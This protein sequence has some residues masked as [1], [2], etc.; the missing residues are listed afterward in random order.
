MSQDTLTL[1]AARRVFW[2]VF[3]AT[4][5]LKLLLAGVFPFTGDEAFFYQWGVRPAWHYSDHPPL[6]GWLLALLHAVSDAPLVLRSVTLLVTSAIALLVVDLLRRLLPEDRE[7]QAWLAGAVYLAMPWSWM[8]VLVTTDTLLILF[9]ALSFWAYVRADGADTADAG[10]RATAWYLLCGALLGAAFFSKYF[11]ALLGFAYAAHAWGWRRERWWAPF[12]V[13]ATAL[14]AIAANLYLNATHGWSHVMFNVFNRNE[15]SAWSLTTWLTYVAMALYLVTPWWLWRAARSRAPEGVSRTARTTLAVLWL[16]PFAVFALL[17]MRRTIGLHWVLGFVPVFVV[18]AGLRT[19][20]RP[21]RRLLTYTTL[22]S[23][24]HLVAVLLIALAP[25]SWFAH[26]KWADRAVFLR[27]NA[28]VVAGL[29]QGLPAG[30]TLMAQAYNPAAMLAF[31]AGVYIPVFGPGRHHARQDDQIVDFRTYDGRPIRVFH[32]DEPD[33]ARY[34]PYFERVRKQSYEVDGVRFWYVDGEGF[35]Y[36]PYRDEVLAAVARDFH[37]I[38]RWLPV[39][40]N[41]FC[42]RYGFAACSPGR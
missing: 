1:A 40:G 41:P 4:L 7:A 6:V 17:A 33:L 24:P 9:M 8:F 42:E 21:L 22:L 39:L 38:P 23:L 11:A 35:R 5:A 34:A 13:F 28:A 10:G 18:W 12:L 37:D 36:Q 20:V 16:F 31:R 2:W 30:A 29:R 14:P 25:L 15:A 32:Y 27:E 3:A 19:D 26:T